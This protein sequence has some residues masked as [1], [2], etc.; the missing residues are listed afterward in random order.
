MQSD[1]GISRTIHISS[2]IVGVVRLTL[3]FTL[4]LML[5]FVLVHQMHD[6]SQLL[7][8]IKDQRE[9][10]K[11]DYVAESLVS[12]GAPTK[13]IGQ[14][15]EAVQNASRA[16]ALP[17]QLLIAL[18]YT[19]ST[20]DEDAVSKKRYKGLMQIPQEIPYADANILVGA[21]ILEDK[22]RIANGDL[23]VA[24]AMYKGGRDIPQ[25][26]RY[27]AH[28]IAVYRRLRDAGGGTDGSKR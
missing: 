22:V 18:M 1:D 17:W 13:K 28:T 9:A 20:F 8:P 5:I 6:Y 25:A 27:A 12:L 15:S 7:V 4:L 14:L 16:T 23:H 19:E 26:R 24:L 3:K 21:R 2:A 11:T 10:P